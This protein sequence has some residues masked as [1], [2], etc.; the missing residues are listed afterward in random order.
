MHGLAHSLLQ[1]SLEAECPRIPAVEMWIWRPLSRRSLDNIAITTVMS[2][3][4][5]CRIARGGQDVVRAKN[6]AETKAA[7]RELGP[8]IRE[9]SREV[10]EPG[11]RNQVS[12]CRNR[13]GRISNLSQTV[14]GLCWA[15]RL[16]FKVRGFFILGR[17]SGL[18]CLFSS[19]VRL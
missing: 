9:P 7:I 12:R 5:V 6:H 11:F 17:L 3:F 4:R 15:C 10:Q 18:L 16:R 2:L 8:E 19:W 13:D 14:E 1:R